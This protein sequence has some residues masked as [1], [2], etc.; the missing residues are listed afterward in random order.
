[1]AE[2]FAIKIK[3]YCHF[4]IKDIKMSRIDKESLTQ[5]IIS[6]DVLIKLLMSENCTKNN[7]KKGLNTTKS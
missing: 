7:K 2:D 4:L 1:M 3:K 6:K 5:Y